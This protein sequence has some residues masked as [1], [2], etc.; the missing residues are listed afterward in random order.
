MTRRLVPATVA[1]ALVASLAGAATPTRWFNLTVDE[2]RDGTAVTLHLPLTL[3]TRVLRAVDGTGVHHGRV[4]FDRHC[5][6]DW[7][8]SL[9]E[10]RR[11]PEG[12]DVTIKGRDNDAVLHKRGDVVVIDASDH[13]GERVKI[14]LR[15]SLLAALSIDR[16]GK[17]DLEALVRGLDATAVGELLT[18]SGPDANVRMWVE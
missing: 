8:Q 18:V 10:L 9:D 14:T 7:A 6:I 5:D 4:H 11:A 16:D 2:A 1:M 15:S 12:A 17:L 13:A 3:V